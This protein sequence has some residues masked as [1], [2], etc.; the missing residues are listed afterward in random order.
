MKV[1]LVRLDG[2]G[3]ALICTPLIAALRTAGHEL[4]WR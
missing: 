3:D 2:I 4:G 1:L